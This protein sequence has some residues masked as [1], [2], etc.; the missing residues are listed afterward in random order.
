MFP[1]MFESISVAPLPTGN[2][3][4]NGSVDS[5]QPSGMRRLSRSRGF[6]RGSRGGTGGTGGTGNCSGHDL[7]RAREV[8]NA[9][10]MGA[11][12]AISCDGCDRVRRVLE[13][14][15]DRVRWVRWVR[16]VRRVR[17]VRCGAKAR[18]LRAMRG[19]VS[20]T[21]RQASATRWTSS[22]LRFLS[23]PAFMSETV[24][25]SSATFMRSAS[26]R[27][28]CATNE[29]GSDF[30]AARLSSIA[31]SIDFRLCAISA[32]TAGRA[33]CLCDGQLLERGDGVQIVLFGELQ[34]RRGVADESD[35]VSSL[36]PR[37]S[38]PNAEPRGGAQHHHERGG[39][40]ELRPG[41]SA[42]PAMPRSATAR[43][44]DLRRN[45]SSTPPAKGYAGPVWPPPRGSPSSR[46]QLAA[47][48]ASA[49]VRVDLRLPL[50]VERAVNRVA[51]PFTALFARHTA[52]VRSARSLRRAL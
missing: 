26:S 38:V 18:G 11:T 36:P 21:H 37:R 13:S 23:G 22:Y 20:A 48:R 29:L 10:R 19:E 14:R 17:Q 46:Q 41:G 5:T 24:S 35:A 25:C 2:A 7:L 4:E 27:L 45:G 43:G 31:R 6:C 15:C 1:E 44:V 8:L 52:A 40:G 12:G 51:E 39:G 33:R 34:L 28:V 50:G 30:S 47:G 16:W 9:V 42:M 32:A 3:R 49:A